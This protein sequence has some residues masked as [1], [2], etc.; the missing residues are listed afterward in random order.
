MKYYNIALAFF[1][2][3]LSLGIVYQFGFFDATVQQIDEGSINQEDIEKQAEAA[4]GIQ[5]QGGLLGD[6]NYLVQ[7]VRLVISGV[8]LFIEAFG[9]AVYVRPMLSGLICRG[10]QCGSALNTVINTITV[11]VETTYLIGII[12]MVTGRNIEQMQ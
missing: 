1:I 2:L 11:L 7:Q 8:F 5:R 4:S 3:N 12:Q 10:F 6:L 9:N